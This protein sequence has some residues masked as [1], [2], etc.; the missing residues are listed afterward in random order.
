MKSHYKKGDNKVYKMVVSPSDTATFHGKTV[1]DVCST[2][3]L[4]RE[5]EWSSRL[6]VL[7]MK[8]DDEE[9]IGTFVNI[10][11]V[12]PAFPG[13]EIH[14]NA[15]V[16]RIIG[17]EIVCDIVATTGNRTVARG[18]TGQKIISKDK[19]KAYFNKLK[20]S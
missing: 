17:N 7:D 19:L 1:H 9:G 12:G 11:H 8:G 15:T 10:D 4:A 5:M 13:E 3:V 2:F 20:N 18:K 16:N 14:F 6:F